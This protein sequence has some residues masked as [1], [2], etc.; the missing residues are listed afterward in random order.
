MIEQINDRMI[1]HRR[2]CEIL[3]EIGKQPTTCQRVEHYGEC[4]EHSVSVNVDN[5]ER[6][7]CQNEDG[8]G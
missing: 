8:N 4:V 6:G 5:V 7:N 1:T 3:S 2:L